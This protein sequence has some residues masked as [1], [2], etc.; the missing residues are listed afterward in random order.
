MLSSFRAEIFKLRRRTASWVLAIIVVLFIALFGYLSLYFQLSAVEQNASGENAEAIAEANAPLLRLLL[1]A[2]VP[3]NV[4]LTISTLGGAVALIFGALSFG[5]EY[6]WETLKTVLP[7]S[8]KRFRMFFG[9]FLAVAVF[10]SIFCVLAFAAGTLS[11]YA[12]AVLEDAPAQGPSA[13]EALRAVGAGWLIMTAWGTIGILLAI[14]FRGT[15]IAIGV[16]LVYTIVVENTI[17]TLPIENDAFRTI[18]SALLGRNSGDLASSFG[19]VPQGFLPGASG[20]AVDPA[21][22]TVV[23][24]AYVALSVLVAV[25]VFARQDI[26]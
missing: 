8:P 10:L 6:G 26:T 3:V 15:A 11:S 7:R 4:L 24:L 1:P 17:S 13:G 25:F 9:K 20:D 2:N 12:I 19:S 22:S 5:S 21:Q 18:L 16:G 23:L 14:L